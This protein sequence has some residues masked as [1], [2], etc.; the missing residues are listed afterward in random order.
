MECCEF[1][2]LSDF[3]WNQINSLKTINWHFCGLWN[4]ILVF[5]PKKSISSKFV[6]MRKLISLQTPKLISRKIWMTENF[7]NFHIMGW[8]PKSS[9]FYVPC[10]RVFPHSSGY[11]AYFI[12]L[13]VV[14]TIFVDRSRPP[15]LTSWHCNFLADLRAQ[16]F[17]FRALC[18]K[19][20]LRLL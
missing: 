7:L 15:S 13:V 16:I 14:G 19:T 12:F 2:Y 9:V 6:I 17:G 5:I 1:F 8:V 18:I 20:I 3:T 11:F 10:N 4:L